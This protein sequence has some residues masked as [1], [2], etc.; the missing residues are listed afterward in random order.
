MTRTIDGVYGAE[1]TVQQDK[2]LREMLA[3][4]TPVLGTHE[5]TCGDCDT[6]VELPNGC[7]NRHCCTCGGAKRRRWAETTCSQILPVEYCHLILTVPKPITQL[8]MLNPGALYSTGPARGRLCGARRC[9]RKLFGVELALLSLLHSWGQLMLPHLHTHSL[10]P[11]G[12]LRAGALEWIDLSK[13]QLE[14]LLEYVGREFPKRFC[15]ALRKAYNQGELQFHGDPEL[16]HLQSPAAFEQWLEPWENMSWI[17]RCG[18]SWDRR[19]ADFG[20]EATRKVVEYLA[21]YVGRIALSDSRI[22]DIDGD[23]VL[24]K[25]KDYRD[26]N[27]QKTTWIEGVE[28]IHRFLKHLLPPKMH[29][30]RRYG[31]MARRAGNEKFDWLLKYHGVA[32][33]EPDEEEEKSDEADGEFE[34]PE[35][36][37]TC[38]FCTG[39]MH[40]TGSTFRPRVS[41]ILDMPLARFRQAQAGAIVTLGA[42]LP[43]ILAE[44]SGDESLPPIS[45]N[46]LETGVEIVA[47]PPGKKLQSIDLLSGG[48]K[49]LTA[50]SLIFAMFL[51]KPTPFCLLDEVDAPL[52]EANVTRFN[53]IVREMSSNSQFILITHNRRTMEIVDR[54][55]GVTMEDPGISKLV[56]VNLSQVEEAA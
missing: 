27:Q 42:K 6:V 25:Y 1:L 41:D 31:W 26:N 37:Q 14:E 47:Q 50:V 40:L 21:N 32:D 22:L 15:K 19:K 18:D 34:E 55:Y 54:L 17:V 46:L 30:I 5:W 10:L 9:G 3:C 8:A 43:Q 45:E 35:R 28:L 49:A 39:S 53:E 23:W 11:L 12:G 29:H 4:Y 52:D 20:P 44:R 13:E 48:E 36:T 2:V 7:N 33:P 38:R 24:F 16:A 56:S 51:V